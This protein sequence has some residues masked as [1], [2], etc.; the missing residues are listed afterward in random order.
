MR[1]KPIFSRNHYIR[2]PVETVQSSSATV[3]IY[4]I[5]GT[6]YARIPVSN[7]QAAIRLE[8]G[9]FYYYE[10]T[11]HGNVFERGSIVCAK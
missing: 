1:S 9:G 7:K 3:T 8:T 11:V 10:C 5:S 6:I 4:T 2:V